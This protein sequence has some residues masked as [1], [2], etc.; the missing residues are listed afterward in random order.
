MSLKP[1]KKSDLNKEW[2]RSRGSKSKTVRINPEYHLIFTE[3]TDTEPN[4]FEAIKNEINKSFKERI[5]VEIEGAGNNTVNLFFKAKAKAESN[6]NG[7]KHVWV[8][9]DTDDFPAE[10]INKTAELCVKY[11]TEDT[12]YHAIWSNQCIEL[13]FLLHFGFYQ[14][15]IHRNEYGDK[16]T[17]YLSNMDSG[18]YK[19]GRDDM[20][21]ILKPYIERAIENAK[22]LEEKNKGKTPADSAPGTQVYKIIEKL[23]PYLEL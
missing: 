21:D 9:Y 13:W 3:G 10:H 23:K 6:P 2:L 17:Q 7:F 11:S 20:Y 14:S 4:Y 8:V 22:K 15:D 1:T 18:E 19:K 5:S 12:T 16:L